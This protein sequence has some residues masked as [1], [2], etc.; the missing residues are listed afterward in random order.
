[1]LR[2]PKRLCVVLPTVMLGCLVGALAPPIADGAANRP[3]A[4]VALGDSSAAGEGGGGY[5]AGTRGEGGDWCHR[6]PNAYVQHTGL[7][8]T[9]INLACSGA[10]STDVAFGA[11]SHYTERSQ[12]EQL[13]D[14]ARTRRVTTVLV[15]LGA[16]DEPAFGTTVVRCVA[17]F[18]SPR[19]PNCSSALAKEWPGRLAAM[20]PRVQRA[21]ADV[22]TGLHSA[23][24]RDQDYQLV[25]LSYSSPVT[26]MMTRPHGVTGC[27]YRSEDARWGRTVG[28]P[29]LSATL[30]G[31]AERSGARFLDLARAAE[32]HEACTTAGP[33]WVRRLTVNPSVFVYGGGL[34]AAGH[35]AQ[36]SFH[37]NATGYARVASCLTQFVHG[38]DRQAACR[39]GSDGALRP[40]AEVPAS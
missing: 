7:A 16:N 27:P 34:A 9:A 2:L 24:Y 22:R 40:V 35:L 31:V 29:Q 5:V 15:Q 21:L 20:A 26:E 13:T 10:R 38:G 6:S 17:V 4:I 19:S 14:V 18:L 32:G 12:A 25:L 30:R 39:I 8:S 37:P 28:V 1:M 23:G 33:E 36:E 11:P 3:T